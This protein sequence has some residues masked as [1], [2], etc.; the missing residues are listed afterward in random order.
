MLSTKLP[1]RPWASTWY[2]ASANFTLVLARCADF[3]MALTIAPTSE[4]VTVLPPSTRKRTFTGKVSPAASG[5]QTSPSNAVRSGPG[6]PLPW[7][8]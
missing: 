5:T 8:A 1:A 6:M 3:W 2:A 4:A 7:S